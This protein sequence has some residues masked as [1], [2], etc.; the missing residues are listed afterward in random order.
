MRVFIGDLDMAQSRL[1]IKVFIAMLLALI[2]SSAWAQAYPV[3]PIRM[4]VP[5]AAGGVVDAT[6]RLLTPK[7]G[8][9]LTQPVIIDNRPGAG[10]NIAAD[11]VAKAPADGYT[12]LITTAGHAISPGLYKKLPF[13]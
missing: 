5:F 9:V 13:D 3:K 7:M 11:F 2:A 4:V 10:G 6:A 12:V 1:N 8:E